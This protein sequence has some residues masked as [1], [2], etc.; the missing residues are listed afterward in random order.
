MGS[1]QRGSPAPG[2]GAGM[3]KTHF[4][5][6]ILFY[7]L[8]KH[9][10]LIRITSWAE[11]ER[12]PQSLLIKSMCVAQTPPLPTD[13]GQR[14]AEEPSLS[15][16]AWGDGMGERGGAEAEQGRE[17]MGG[18]EPVAQQ[19]GQGEGEP[20]QGVGRRGESETLPERE[21]DRERR[22]EERRVQ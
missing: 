4:T 20:E 7:C 5:F 8:N 19:Q 14:P 21:R 18:R 9:L 6:F 11:P 16:S 3:E 22:G 2:A 13:R 15:C 17:P 10:G 1:A 12:K